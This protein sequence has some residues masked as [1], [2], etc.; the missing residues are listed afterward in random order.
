[1]KLSSK[2]KSVLIFIIFNIFKTYM[3]RPAVLTLNKKYWVGGAG[4]RS[5]YL[6]HAKRALY[7]L[8]YAP[9]I[10]WFL[11]NKVLLLSR[12]FASLLLPP[13]L[14][15]RVNRTS[16]VLNGFDAHLGP[17][18]GLKIGALLSSTVLTTSTVRVW[19]GRMKKSPE[20]SRITWWPLDWMAAPAVNPLLGAGKGRFGLF[21]Y[22]SF[23]IQGWL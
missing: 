5:R 21:T 4:Y 17:P 14:M 12:L 13:T 9:V 18:S 19:P 8:S 2:F 15:W 11:H 20:V 1:M 3:M 16:E 22:S 6:S 10:L 23:Y 7:H